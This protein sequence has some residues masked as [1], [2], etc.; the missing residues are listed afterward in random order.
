MCGRV[1]ERVRKRVCVRSRKRS[2]PHISAAL[3][4][5]QSFPL[6]SESRREGESSWLSLR[7]LERQV[8]QCGSKNLTCARC[9]RQATA[10]K[11]YNWAS[12]ISWPS[13][14]TLVSFCHFWKLAGL[15][16]HVHNTHPD[17]ER[18][19]YGENCAYYNRILTVHNSPG[20]VRHKEKQTYKKQTQQ[21]DW[22][23][24]KCI[25]SHSATEQVCV[26]LPTSA[27]NV[28]LLTF[29]A[30]HQLCSNRS[31]S[32]CCWAHSIKPAAAMVNKLLWTSLQ[33]AQQL[34]ME[35]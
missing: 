26:Q 25:K 31:T 7:C 11:A 19:N 33:D 21:P 5:I 27:D 16:V 1:P 8:G 9:Q 23:V 15:S 34:F 18:D 20:L 22:T 2:R 28:T 12:A 24:T 13:R 30:E 6:P 14:W 17:F 29:A 10:T 35:E 4:G 3:L 32:P